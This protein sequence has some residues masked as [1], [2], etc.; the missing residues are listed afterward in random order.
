VQLFTNSAAALP[1]EIGPDGQ[2]LRTERAGLRVPGLR[3]A[4]DAWARRMEGAAARRA[5]AAAV[6]AN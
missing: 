6:A 1:A 4:K 3:S 5:A 2:M